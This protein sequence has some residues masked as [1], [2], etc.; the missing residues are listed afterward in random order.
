MHFRRTLRALHDTF[1]LG[2][3]IGDADLCASVYAPNGVVVTPDKD[4]IYGRDMIRDYWQRAM[5]E[6]CRGH[7]LIR[8]RVE[9]RDHQVIE[10]GFYGHFAHPVRREPPT[11]QGEYLVVVER[12]SD[13]SWA[14][15]ID[16]WSEVESSTPRVSR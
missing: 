10:R 2:L 15:A 7:T 14:W 12:Q 13:G 6:G 16:L 11:A 8:E 3:L 4:L 5:D 1:D 9:L